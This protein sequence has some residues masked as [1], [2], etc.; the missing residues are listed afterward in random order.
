M[1]L[2]KVML[3]TLHHDRDQW[4]DT[5]LKERNGYEKLKK[6]VCLALSIILFITAMISISR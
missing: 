1:S 3:G 6:S 4:K 5:L 2:F